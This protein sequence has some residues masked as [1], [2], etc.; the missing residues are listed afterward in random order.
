M[1]IENNL[2]VIFDTAT[3]TEDGLM[4]CQD[5]T[6]LDQIDVYLENKLNKDDKISTSKLDMSS[7]DDIANLTNLVSEVI[8][9]NLLEGTIEIS[10][11]VP[12]NGVSTEKIQNEAV[13]I[14]KIDKRLLLGNVVSPR[15]INFAFSTK[16]VSITIPQGSLLVLDAI[17]K[18]DLITNSSTEDV[19]VNLNYPTDFD[20]LNYIVSEPTGTM[21]MINHRK[22]N[23][24][25]STN[26]IVALVYLSTTYDA[27]IVMHGSYTINGLAQGIG[28]ESAALMSTGK[29][30]FDKLTGII[31]FT[32]ATILHLIIGG[33]FNRTIQN[34][35]S[36][37]LSNYSEDST[38]VLYWN[39]STQTLETDLATTTNPDTDIAK[40]ALIKDGLIVPFVDTRAFYSKPYIEAP[41]YTENFD[42]IN[43]IILSSKGKINIVSIDEQ[44][45]EFPEDTV[46][47]LNQETLEVKTKEC[48]YV[49]RM[50]LHYILFDL[51]EQTISCRHYAE[52]EDTTKKNIV[53]GTIYISANDIIV[54]GNFEY[55]IN[56][57]TAYEDDLLYAE[58]IIE[59]VQNTI[60]S[61]IV[62]NR[63][64]VGDEIYMIDNEELPI[65][66]SSML[67]RSVEGIKSAI[68]Y[69]K[70]NNSMIPRISFFDGNTL[71]DNTMGDNISL[72][73]Y[74]KYN[75]HSYL[76]QDVVIKKVSSDYKN[77]Q[78]IKLMCL[79][80]DLINDKTAY[81][82]NNKLTSLGLNVEMLGT[83]DNS[84]VY[85]EGREGWFYS[86]FLGASGRGKEEGKI[87]PQTAR[88]SSSIL[89]NPFLR[90][91][92]ADDK[93]SNPN[94]CF[95]ATGAYNEKSY[96]SDSD[97]N[98]AFYIFDFAKYLEVQGIE[99]PDVIIIA[100]KPELMSLVTENI[101]SANMTYMKQ[102]ITGIRSALPD[103]YI[104]IIPQ[105]GAC[106]YYEEMWKTTYSMITETIDYVKDLGDDKIKV[107]SA[108][109]H[110]NREFGTEYECSN[111]LSRAAL[112]D[113][114]ANQLYEELVYDQMDNKLSE[115][116]KIEL[117][118]TIAA[119]IMNI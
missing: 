102:L 81:Y 50:G 60:N 117:A 69:N 59:Q 113:V 97:K 93:A 114:S 106:T 43:N 30:V 115:T 53:V 2:P 26:S 10:S 66:E 29:I 34:Q 86:T 119:F 33:V 6:K 111:S 1:A 96:Y 23:T 14:D 54:S 65:Y 64:L 35:S 82:I 77:N 47:C 18:R 91:A 101:V 105:Y 44:K 37:R 28:T 110:M 104:G 3:Q 56:D 58:E 63:I 103:T 70:N 73:A 112:A 38:Y 5:K 48:Q 74:D 76:K 89:M 80:D 11:V 9:K 88:G 116:S 68:G 118:N 8:G 92:N 22:S 62:N 36:I 40:I 41:Y 75:T 49:D 78:D 21:S 45:I 13:T 94:N 61:D 32:E 4:S 108:W 27:A 98:G 83:M 16:Q 72:L 19:V 25:S 84:H 67:I 95:R 39:H 20:G 107:L 85:G 109:L 71:I 31:D 7:A 90:V 100:I 52:V 55:T 99:N 46:V 51:D 15:P 79:G 12:E 24:I 57:K 17:T 87:T 42:K